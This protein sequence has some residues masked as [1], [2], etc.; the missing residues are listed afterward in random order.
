MYLDKINRIKQY[1]ADLGWT[2]EEKIGSEGWSKNRV[3]YYIIIVMPILHSWISW[4]HTKCITICKT[5]S[6]FALN[7]QTTYIQVK[8]SVI[9]VWS[10]AGWKKNSASKYLRKPEQVIMSKFRLSTGIQHTANY[11][12]KHLH[13]I[14]STDHET[15]R[16][17]GLFIRVCIKINTHSC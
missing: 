1:M 10:Q 7:H 2:I 17:R 5:A 3:G 6:S 8:N 9:V 12:R 14:H 11:K 16:F 15:I 13:I 4:M